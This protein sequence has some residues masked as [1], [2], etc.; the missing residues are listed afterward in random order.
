MKKLCGMLK[1]ID[2]ISLL[3]ENLINVRSISM[4]PNIS[5]C[6]RYNQDL[7]MGHLLGL[8]V[9]DNLDNLVTAY[10]LF[11]FGHCRE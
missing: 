5:S 11:F 10:F 4:T 7:L 3:N 8:V 2:E 1:I 6:F 9:I